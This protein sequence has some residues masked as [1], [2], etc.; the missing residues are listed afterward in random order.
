MSRLERLASRS[1]RLLAEGFLPLPEHATVT[2]ILCSTRSDWTAFCLDA[3]EKCTRERLQVQVIPV[4]SYEPQFAGIDRFNLALSQVDTKYFVL[5]DDGVIVTPDWLTRL[6]W[7]FYDDPRIGIVAPSTNSEYNSPFCSTLD[8]LFALSEAIAKQN[9][10]SWETVQNLQGRCIVCRTSLLNEVGGLDYTLKGHAAR[11]LDWILRV[12]TKGHL[13]AL[14]K[15]SYVYELQTVY[16]DPE[17]KKEQRMQFQTSHSPFVPLTPE[18]LA[19]PLVSVVVVSL[20]P[21]SHFLHDA[22]TN[23]ARQIYPNIEVLLI[24]QGSPPHRP[25]SAH[26]PAAGIWMDGEIPIKKALE[27]IWRLAKGLYIAYL[28]TGY[29]FETDHISRL[30]DSIHKNR[31]LV[32][33]VYPDDDKEIPLSFVMHRNPASVP[34]DF[35]IRISQENNVILLMNRAPSLEIVKIFEKTVKRRVKS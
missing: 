24:R 19:P 28:E 3:L 18:A 20:H 12:Q 21:S 5:L 26:T 16:T 25:R 9:S 23:V 27:S 7:A 13:L 31:A 1:T 4:H 15:D 8:E 10:G 30:V 34:I 6:L 14:A 11:I 17:E 33:A 29:E 32:G 2:I 22:L 35:D